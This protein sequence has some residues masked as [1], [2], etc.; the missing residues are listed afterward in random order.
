MSSIYSNFG[1][2]RGMELAQ[3]CVDLC[4]Q[5]FPCFSNSTTPLPV[6]IQGAVGV[7]DGDQS[8]SNQIELDMNR[9]RE[10]SPEARGWNEDDEEQDEGRAKS[11]T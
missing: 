4:T 10:T 1:D 6:T 9:Y 11:D 7:A 5:R 3:L 8:N 2:C